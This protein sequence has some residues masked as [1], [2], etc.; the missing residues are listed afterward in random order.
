MLTPADPFPFKE[1]LIK[2]LTK[3]QS[4]LVGKVDLEDTLNAMMLYIERNLDESVFSRRFGNSDMKMYRHKSALN[5]AFVHSFPHRVGS[6]K[7]WDPET[8][9]FYQS[10]TFGAAPYENYLDAFYA[11]FIKTLREV[12]DKEDLKDLLE[13]FANKQDL[14]T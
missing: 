7:N 3:M 12:A 6:L 11:E 5:K 10:I 2:A 4:F 1:T 9:A 14:G 13:L 8:Y